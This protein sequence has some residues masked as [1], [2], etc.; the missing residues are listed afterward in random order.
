MVP[1]ATS[2]GAATAAAD[3]SSRPSAD[4]ETAAAAA[5]AAASA[6]WRGPLPKGHLPALQQGAQEH[7]LAD[8][9]HQPVPQG[10]QPGHLG[11]RLPSLQEDV[12]VGIDKVTQDPVIPE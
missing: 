11:G 12:Q 10:G 6:G 4:Q 2:L 8:R 7:A 1:A 3:G 9:A 5:V